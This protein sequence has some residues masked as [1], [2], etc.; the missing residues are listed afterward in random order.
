MRRSTRHAAMWGLLL[1]FLL[2]QGWALFIQGGGGIVD[3][4][5]FIEGF[6]EY[7]AMSLAD[8]LLTA[9]VIDFMTVAVVI[10]AWMLAE[11]P[12]AQRLR[13]RTFLWLAAFCVF[14]GLGVLLYFLW[15]NPQHPLMRGAD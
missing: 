7:F 8:P 1:L 15:L 5:T 3:R 13:P 2:L 9:G 14:P 11:L 6:T 4:Y 12:A 10:L